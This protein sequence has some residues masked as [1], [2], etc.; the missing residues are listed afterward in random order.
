MAKSQDGHKRRLRQD[1]ALEDLVG[2]VEN[3][4]CVL[5]AEVPAIEMLELKLPCT[6]PVNWV[7]I[8]DSLAFTQIC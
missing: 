1:Q 8:I 3:L 7:L 2:H 5:R 6:Y 4:P